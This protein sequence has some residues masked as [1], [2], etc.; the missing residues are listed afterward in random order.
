M[1]YKILDNHHTLK[2]TLESNELTAPTLEVYINDEES[3]VESY[4]SSSLSSP[5]T[6][7][8]PH[9]DYEIGDIITKFKLVQSEELLPWETEEGV[10]ILIDGVE[11]ANLNNTNSSTI[12]NTNRVEYTTQFSAGVHDIQTF[13][14]GNNEYNM[15]MTDKLHFVVTQ[16]E[17]QEEAETDPQNTGAYRLAFYG[18]TKLTTVYGKTVKLTLQLTKGGVPVNGKTVEVTLGGN[19]I[20]SKIT[21][22]KGLAEFDTLNWSAGKYKVGG[23]FTENS[24]KIYSIYKTFTIEKAK[25][26]ITID[27][28]EYK[29]DG[30]IKF[31]FKYNDNTAITNTKVQLYVNGKLTTYTTDKWG[32][33]AYKFGSKGTFKFKAIYKGTNNIEGQEFTTSITISE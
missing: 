24:K 12:P 29:K 11:V 32:K 19:G 28:G 3:P 20:G 16:P 14:V 4:T 10:T 8:I 23:F 25:S 1:T 5:Y 13:Y 26:T 18:D 6:Y 31:Y 22:N 27:G 30:T 33:I 15:A 2:L 17:V 21:Q 7:E 9:S